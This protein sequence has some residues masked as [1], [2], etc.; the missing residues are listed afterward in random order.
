MFDEIKNP[1]TKGIFINSLAMRLGVRVFRSYL[2]I[3][4]LLTAFQ[5]GVEYNAARQRV[6]NDLQSISNSFKESLTKALWSMDGELINSEASGMISAPSVTGLKII[7]EDNNILVHLG[8][9]FTGNENTF[10]N[11]IS[12]ELRNL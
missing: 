3:A 12:I 5:L 7:D 8:D 4:F 9:A 10:S 1:T 11:H 6:F 2:I